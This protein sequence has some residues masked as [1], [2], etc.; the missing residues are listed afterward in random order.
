MR[1]SDQPAFILR[2]REWRNSSLIV[3]LLT[4]DHGRVRVLARGA[5]RAGRG[6]AWQPFEIL[7][8]GWAGSGEL[9]TL[10][11]A[12]AQ[13]LPVDERNYLLLLYVNELLT[14]VLPDSDPGPALFGR[15]FEL[16]QAASDELDEAEL[17]RFELD[18]LRQLGYLPDLERE[19][20]S[21]RAI[22]ADSSYAFYPD[23][24]FVACAP[25]ARDAVSGDRVLAWLDD[26][27]R[28]PAV[29]RLARAVLRATIDFNLHGKRLKSRDVFQQIKG[30]R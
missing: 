17:R 2:R 14:L 7:S 9:K 15:Y 29:R 4:R 16:L 8:V 27:Y 10:T 25:A 20:A 3:D 12:E 11:G 30:L 28:D 24:G 6:L 5:R 26:D 18:L 21:G 1:I 22:A 13:A 23:Q 19:A